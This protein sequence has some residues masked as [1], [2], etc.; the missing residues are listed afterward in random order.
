MATHHFVFHCPYCCSRLFLSVE[1]L[2]SPVFQF[3]F[4]FFIALFSLLAFCSLFFILLPFPD[5]F[6]RTDFSKASV[7]ISILLVRFFAPFRSRCFFLF[8]PLL[9]RVWS[10]KDA[11]LSSWNGDIMRDLW[12]WW[13][14]LTSD[15][16]FWLFKGHPRSLI[17]ADPTPTCSG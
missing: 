12:A 4:F 13:T 14:H 9:I 11:T 16:A 3:A 6:Y 2:S 5:R 7:F 8:R 10:R 15:I 1:F 17:L